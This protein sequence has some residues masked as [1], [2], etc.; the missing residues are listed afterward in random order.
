MFPIDMKE[1]FSVLVCDHTQGGRGVVNLFANGLPLG[2]IRDGVFEPDAMLEARC[3]VESV[4]KLPSERLAAYFRWLANTVESN[5]S[6]VDE[7]T[8]WARP[9]E[10]RP[11]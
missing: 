2:V 9:G 3:P 5:Q 10:T 6:G 7:C 1:Y 8:V 4:E 11:F